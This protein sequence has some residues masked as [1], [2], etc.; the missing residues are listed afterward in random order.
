[1]PRTGQSPNVRIRPELLREH[2]KLQ[3]RV[4]D[5][6]GVGP[7]AVTDDVL[8]SALDEIGKRYFQ[9]LCF[10]VQARAED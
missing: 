6:L 1:M 2:R 4:I 9:E 10:E 7:R 3:R 5:Y 8:L